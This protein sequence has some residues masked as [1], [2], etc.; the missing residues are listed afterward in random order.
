MKQLS[1]RS[2]LKFC[3]AS[4]VGIGLDPFDLTGLGR[5]LAN[6]SGPTVLWL[7][8][9]GCTGCTVSL[10]DYI[11]PTAP[12]DVADVLI[13]YINLAY[14]PNLSSVAGEAAV[15]VIQQ[16][17]ESGNYLLAVEGGIPT[18]FGGGA[19]FAWSVRGAEVTFAEAVRDLASRA[20]AIMC[21]GTCSAY[22]GIPAAP[23]NPS[24]VV[25]VRNL[26]GRPTI[27]VAG[28][29]PHPDWIIWTIVQLLLGRTVSLDGWG[30]PRAI[31]GRKIHD[32]CPRKG[33][34]Q[35]RSYA[36]PGLCLK[37][38]GCRG[39]ASHG[40]CPVSQWNNNTN[41]CVGANAPCTGCTSPEF[42]STKPFFGEK[43]EA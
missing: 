22:G 12:V 14:A 40:T 10:L 30:R 43:Y 29:P 19:C 34:Q 36:V 4:A 8:G 3:T 27:N 42:P 15:S 21:I 24:G 7:Q 16:V 23:P 9:S 32:Q 31:F 1:R 28:C 20:K 25:S 13:N 5:A 6:P 38:L 11:S 17:F 26:T 41:W 2:F 33:K 37:E 39:P 18:G 35:A